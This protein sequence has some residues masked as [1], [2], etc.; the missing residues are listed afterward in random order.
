V[1]PC[2]TFPLDLPRVVVAEL[3]AGVVIGAC[4]CASDAD[5]FIRRAR[6]HARI[7]RT[8]TLVHRDALEIFSRV[9][10]RIPTPE[11][12]NAPYPVTWDEALALLNECA[13][14]D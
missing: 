6:T 4:C 1:T 14:R 2:N 5:A 9:A 8:F 12:E 13:D 11:G 3:D 7:G 10:R